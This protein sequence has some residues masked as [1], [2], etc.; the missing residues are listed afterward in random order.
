M[1]SPMLSESESGVSHWD[2]LGGEKVADCRIFNIVSK[3]FR[4][5]KRKTEGDFYVIQTRDWVNIVPITP[6]YEMILVN[7]FRFGVKGTSWEIPGGVMDAGED[8]IA[9]G[10]REMRE[11][12]GYTSSKVS[13]LGSVRPNPAIQ[14]NTCHMVLAEQA[15]LTDMLEW[16]EHEEIVTRA[17][18]VQEVYKMVANGE[19]FHSLALNALLMFYPKW[20]KIK[21]RQRSV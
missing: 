20:E 14:D 13:L 17:V 21:S 3:R 6:N 10:L 2:E 9:A 15:R 12:T 1:T 7:Q 16:D 4:H 18:P 5:P 8:P 11:E 19:I